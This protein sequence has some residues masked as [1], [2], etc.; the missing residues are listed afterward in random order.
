MADDQK[1]I[2]FNLDPNKVPV[3]SIDGYLISS[4]EHNLTLNFAQAMMD[5]SQQNVV[6]RVSM[7]PSQAK[8]FLKNLAD[9]IDKFEV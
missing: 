4:N 8:E 7:S 5:G 9:H 1:Q 2:N 6:T 3:L